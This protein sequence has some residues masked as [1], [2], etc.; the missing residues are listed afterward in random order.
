MRYLIAAM[1][2]LVREDL[3]GSRLDPNNIG[4]VCAM[5]L[6]TILDSASTPVSSQSLLEKFY[7]TM[8][9]KDEVFIVVKHD[10][11]LQLYT[12]AHWRKVNQTQICHGLS[13][14]LQNCS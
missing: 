9:V 4:P 1:V 7:K 11:L 5:F 2:T 10:K 14:F 12:T 3:I 8:K 13:D 6:S